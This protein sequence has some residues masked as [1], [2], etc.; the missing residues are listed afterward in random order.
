[1]W[2]NCN[3]SYL[4][5][6]LRLECLVESKHKLSWR[7]IKASWS[8]ELNWKAVVDHGYLWAFCAWLETYYWGLAWLRVNYII[9]DKRICR[10]NK[11]V[12]CSWIQLSWPN[13]A[14]TPFLLHFW[15]DVEN[16]ISLCNF[17][18]KRH[19]FKVY[20]LAYL[21]REVYLNSHVIQIW[22]NSK[23]SIKTVLW[24]F[25]NFKRICRLDGYPLAIP[26]PNIYILKILCTIWVL[27]VYHINHWL[28]SLP[29]D[30]INPLTSC[31]LGFNE[32]H[33]CIRFFKLDCLTSTYNKLNRNW[34]AVH[35]AIASFKDHVSLS[36][37]LHCQSNICGNICKERWIKSIS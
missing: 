8:V 26:L 3:W 15:K 34:S 36:C 29:V 17:S 30:Y 35:N 18:S 13:Y 32:C 27:C 5:I 7:A 37:Y 25:N 1:M 20:L 2:W 33:V 9:L 14:C 6:A 28:N 11:S 16:W 23:I 24:A 10:C 12:I 22:F 4:L 31:R 21:N 19:I